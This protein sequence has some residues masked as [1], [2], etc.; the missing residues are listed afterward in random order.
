MTPPHRSPFA[1]RPRAPRRCCAAQ[2]AAGLLAAGL[3]LLGPAPAPARE[4]ESPVQARRPGEEVVLADCLRVAVLGFTDRNGPL[5]PADWVT[6]RVRNDCDEPARHL[7][8]D[9][10]LLDVFGQVYGTRV[11]VLERGEVLHPG[12]SKTERYAVPD[13]GEHMPRQWAVRLQAVEKPSDGPRRRRPRA[14]Q[15]PVAPGSRSVPVARPAPAAPA[16]QPAPQEAPPALTKTAPASRR[17]ELS[18][19]RR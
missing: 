8:V 13:D 11:W 14:A 7:L 6:L 15:V 4:G 2:V 1:H 16:A 9:L 18:P 5:Q 10:L 3:L 19:T 12:Q 17:A